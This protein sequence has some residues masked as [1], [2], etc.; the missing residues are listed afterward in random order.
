MP[1]F[2]TYQI[3]STIVAGLAGLALG[4]WWVVSPQSY[5]R[6]TLRYRL[7][8]RF[9]PWPSPEQVESRWWRVG[10]R[11][12]GIAALAFTA[13]YYYAAYYNLSRR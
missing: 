12:A 8:Y 3:V 11:T 13:M 9:I 2:V 5:M 6:L 1:R 7:K 10:L 4:L